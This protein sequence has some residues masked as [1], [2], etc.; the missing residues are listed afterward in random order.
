[1]RTL[2]PYQ[3]IKFFREYGYIKSILL[4]SMLLDLNLFQG[5]WIYV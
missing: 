3:A 1:M 5:V 4:L 2:C